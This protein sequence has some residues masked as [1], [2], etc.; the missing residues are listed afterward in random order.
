MTQVDLKHYSEHVN[1]AGVALIMAFAVWVA[2][3]AKHGWI[4]P[5]LVAV[6]VC[7]VAA[8]GHV[9]YCGLKKNDD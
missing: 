7:L 3:T 5:I 6:A 9:M 1:W 4:M 8:Q 2:F